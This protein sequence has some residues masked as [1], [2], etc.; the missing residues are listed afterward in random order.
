MAH[1]PKDRVLQNTGGHAG[2]RRYNANDLPKKEDDAAH[3][4][5]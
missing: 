3:V 1:T 2:V 4:K 5:T